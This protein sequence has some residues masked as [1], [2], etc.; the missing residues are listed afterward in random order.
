MTKM[1]NPPTK[2]VVTATIFRWRFYGVAAVLIFLVLSLVWHLVKLQ[3]LPDAHRGFEFL[4]GQGLAR[5]L[6]TESIPA[7]RGVI[8]DRYGEPLAVSTPV[9]SLWANPKE[10]LAVPER[11]KEL[12]A[13][14]GLAVGSLEEKLQRYSSKEFMYLQRQM[15]PADAQKILSLKIKGVYGQQEYQ[16][17]YPAGEVAAHLVGFTNVDDQGQEGLELAYNQWLTGTPGKKQVLKDLSGRVIKDVALLETAASGKDIALS[18]DLRLQYL[19]YRELK[20]AVKAHGAKS[21]SVVLLDVATGE[22]LAMANQPSFNPNDRSG[23]KID[24]LRNRAITDQ[25][26]PGSTM[27]PLTIMAALETGRYF[28]Y[29]TVD[30]NPG[31]FKVG[32]KTL[33]DPVNYGVMDLTKIITKS[34]QVGLTKVSLD[35]DP[36]AIRDMFFRLGLGQSTGTGFPG[37]SL[38]LLPSYMRWQ[39]IVQAN[40]SFGYGLTLTALQL[41]QAYSVIAD[42]GEKKPVSILKIDRQPASEKVIDEKVALQMIDMLKTVVLSGGTAKNANLEDYTV[43]G[44]TGTIHKVGQQGYADDRYTSLFVGFAPADKPRLIAVVVVNEPSRGKY[45]GGEVAA[46]V[47]AKVMERSLQLM[48]VPPNKIRETALNDQFLQKKSVKKSVS[49]MVNNNVLQF[50][51]KKDTVSAESAEPLT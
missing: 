3:V 24:A 8:T 12:S 45:Y 20:A 37:E 35:L 43:A 25:F 28:P 29:T 51:P 9:V 4:Q 49:E 6:R 23:L 7:Y 10:L 36:N 18:I 5:T 30:T 17:F 16:R 11:W 39:P 31:Y 50:S 2:K 21:G 1:L 13:H 46:P 15:A 32:S 44:K 33:L 34:S 27:K 14:A 47:F 26:E 48:Q 41:A 38:G 42:S 19:A 22:V 40:F